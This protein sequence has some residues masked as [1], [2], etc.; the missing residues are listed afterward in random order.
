MAALVKYADS[1]SAKDPESDGEKTGKDNRKGQRHNP[2]NQN[3]N[4]RKA[5]DNPELVANI[6]T[7]GNNQRHKGEWPRSGGLYT[8]LHSLWSLGGF[9]K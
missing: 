2:E 8:F 3:S 1:D 4:K 9:A 6:N 7:Q 5:D